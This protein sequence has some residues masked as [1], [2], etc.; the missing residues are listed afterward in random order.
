MQCDSMNC[1]GGFGFVRQG[2]TNVEFR[3]CSTGGKT[4]GGRGPRERIMGAFDV[5]MH[6]NHC[7]DT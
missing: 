6:L 1:I 3:F 4:T 5:N 7:F 2:T